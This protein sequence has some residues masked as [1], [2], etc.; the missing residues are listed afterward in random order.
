MRRGNR[1]AGVAVIAGLLL[2]A[3]FALHGN[4]GA[5][6]PASQSSTRASGFFARFSAGQTSSNP[7]GGP[8]IT[9]VVRD[10]KGPVAGVRVSA[11]RVEP[12]VT[13][14][15]R[16]CPLSDSAP[17]VPG[18]PPPRLM[19]CPDEAFDELVEQVDQREG[20]APTVAEATSAEDGTFVLDG[21]PGGSVTLQATRGQSV[22]MRPDVTTGQQG[23][24]L[25]L[26]EGLFFEGI[27]LNEPP[28]SE[29][30]VGARITVFSHEHTRFFPATSGADG[31][32]RIGPVPPADYGILVT[33]QDRGPLLRMRADPLEDGT[34]ILD[35]P[36]KYAGTV[37]TEKG[38]PAPGVS[39]RLYTPSVTP[40]SRT[41]LTDARG[42]FSFRSV[43]GPPGQ[44]FAETAT[45]D[46]LASV[47]TEPREDVVL[48]LGPGMV[49]HGTVSDDAG[50]P[51]P[52]ARVQADLRDANAPSQRGQTVTD[53]RG[54]YRL[55]PLFRL[56]HFV[57]VRAAHHVDA[58][59]E[60][61]ELG[62]FEEQ[63]DFTLPRAASVEGVLVDE[64]GQPLAGRTVQLH[65]GPV[66]PSEVEFITDHAVTDEAGRFVLDASAEGPA[67]LDV[68]D[69]TFVLQRLAVELPSEPVRMVL[70]RGT[71]V[72]LTVLSAA[73]APVR[74][75]Q[76]TLWKRDAR[77]EADR[78]EVTD[79]HG[80]ATLQGVSPG[81]YV[82]EA[83]VPGRAADVHASQPLD[84]QTGEA[85]SVTLRLEEG[86]TLRGIVVSLQGR[87][88]PG[89]ALRAEVLEADRPRYRGELSRPGLAPEGVRTDAE[90]RFTLR[91]LSAARQVLTARLPE[92]VVATA[93]S[94]GVLAGGDDTSVVV[95]RDTA[96]VRLV[97]RRI[98]HVR[99]R[100]VA[101]GG[102]ALESFDVNGL[103]YTNPDGRFDQSLFE[104]TGAQRLLVRS[105]G[106]AHEDRTV[107]PDGENDLD[108]GT[109]TL[110]RGR[111]VR[112]LLREASTG[113]P[114]NGSRLDDDGR[115]FTAAVSCQ[116]H[117][118]GAADGPP[119]PHPSW[120]A[121]REDGTLLLEHM[122]LAA[123]TLFVDTQFHLPS[124]A[125]V[126]AEEE[127]ITLPLDTGARVKG[128]IRDARGQPFKARLTFTRSDGL[129]QSQDAGPGDF[130]LSPVPPGLYTVTAWAVDAVHDTL[131][132]ARSVRIPPSGDVTL[133]FDALDSG[134]TVTLRLTEDVDSVVLLPGQPSAPA[135]ARDLDLLGLQRRPL[136]EWTGRSVTFRRVAAGHYTVLASTRDKDRLHREEL[137]VPAEGALSLD[138]RPVWLPL[139]R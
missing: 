29:P 43:E 37:L 64:E 139:A 4:E 92:H 1:A 50:R 136:E 68:D 125:R 130:T 67:W 12:E 88:L 116:V 97:L 35:R 87:P 134:A 48:T 5:S 55:G 95:G 112:V 106:F 137:D 2:G 16:S 107:T 44:L 27:V 72:S 31:R 39:V 38:A 138:V 132:P 66:S 17:S 94:Q 118:E 91:A 45:H 101:E 105:K 121:P 30:V 114:Y 13:L 21:L 36:A 79:A 62:K 127:R 57:A 3:F 120:V 18:E 83:R 51:I 93:A 15:E 90:G 133:D 8:R 20:E 58:E 60:Y 98:P 115:E 113:K 86:R 77:G 34:F 22:A 59:P 129:T 54:R 123:F 19:Q 52:G 128:H 73:G 23:V 56:P 81:S 100:V 104:A 47:R 6:G 26:D 85:P 102:V 135:S 122:P 28:G 124:R 10:A 69:A 103:R 41:V 99:G 110:T 24:V 80:Q 65:P 11:S 61:Q 84:V 117:A 78:V 40:E 42:R 109:V 76:V 131:F 108:L 71:P 7:T 111:T 63:L 32:F 119:F 126:G 33:V 53:A 25:V 46:G 9:G 82:A 74:G 96:E 49:I 14:S 89:V 70:R 75:A